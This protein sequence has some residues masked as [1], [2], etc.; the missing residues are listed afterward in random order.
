[1]TIAS[2]I[3]EG[4]NLPGQVPSWL[5]FKTFYLLQIGCYD[6]YSDDPRYG[7]QRLWMDP[8]T[9]LLVVGGTAGQTTIWEP[10]SERKELEAT[11]VE[12]PIVSDRD[13]FVW[14]GH[15]KVG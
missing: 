15:E 7:I 6:P 13:N 4:V 9:G 5:V 11:A 14:K 2:M 1:M 12:I 10:I 8:A 3:Q